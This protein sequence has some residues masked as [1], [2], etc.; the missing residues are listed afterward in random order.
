MSPP[1]SAAKRSEKQA[2][3]PDERRHVVITGV[4]SGIG[5]I[6][7]SGFASENQTR[8]VGTGRR[9]A[10]E[11]EG[12]LPAGIAYVE[13]D[14][15][16]AG[17]ADII[18]KSLAL[19]R[20]KRIDHL[21]LN[22]ATGRVCEPRDEPP[23]DTARTLQA[24][25]VAPIAIVRALA[26]LLLAPEREQPALV[27]IIGS[28]ARA[29]AP[30]FAS[31]A[32]SKA[33]LAGFARALGSEWRGR[34]DVQLIDLGPTATQMHA[35]AGLDTGFA[36]RFF[37]DPDDCARRIRQLMEKRVS[38]A[39]ITIGPREILNGLRSSREEVA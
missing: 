13:A 8:V 10:A 35:K 25:L 2:P 39:R 15:C 14:Q 29:G 30:R 17:C 9:P 1:K 33:G 34:A 11:M 24:N 6:L 32:A 7:A 31:Y 36:R 26:P 3:R 38:R 18:R 20:W 22:A 16:D 12:A 27:T 28:T 19:R 37:V 4:S 21:V 5:A 23:A